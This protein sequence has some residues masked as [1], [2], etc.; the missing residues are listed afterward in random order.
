M[1]IK[2]L[3]IVNVQIGKD[4]SNWIAELKLFIYLADLE[5]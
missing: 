3:V 4:K 2:L 1:G 5:Q